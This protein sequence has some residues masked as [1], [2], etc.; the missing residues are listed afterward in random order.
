[1]QPK[2]TL[3]NIGSLKRT[4]QY[5]YHATPCRILLGLHGISTEGFLL[6]NQYCLECTLPR[7]MYTSMFSSSSSV[8]CLLLVSQHMSIDIRTLRT[9]SNERDLKL[10]TINGTL[11]L[12]QSHAKFHHQKLGKSVVIRSASDLKNPPASYTSLAVNTK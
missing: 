7:Q 2:Y 9:G 11:N 8:I 6:K 1:M 3:N 5:Y 12:K 10:K 4:L